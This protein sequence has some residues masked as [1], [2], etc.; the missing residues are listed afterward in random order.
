MPRLINVTTGSVV[1]RNV[2][3]ADSWW[4]RLAGFIPYGEIR[5]DDGLWFDNCSAIHTMWMRS[6]I[7]VIFLAQDNRI[8]SIHHSVPQYRLAVVCS[9]ARAVVELGEAPL[10]GRDLLVGDQL[11]LE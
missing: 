2:Q 7:D 1:A 9:G 5:P 11:A 3:K 10:E 8:A 4:K 6:R